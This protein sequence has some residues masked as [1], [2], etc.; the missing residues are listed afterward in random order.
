V[1]K[2]AIATMGFSFGG[3]S[4][5][6]AQVRNGIIQA[7]VS[8]DGSVRYQYPTLKKS[9][10][11]TIDK[12]NVPFI[13]MAQKIIP[14]QV[15]KED[16]IDP[17][18]NNDFFFYDELVESEAYSL[19]FNNLTHSYFSTL[20]VL[21]QPR[22]LRQDKSDNKILESYRWMSYYTLMFLNAYLKKDM[23]AKDF[24]NNDPAEQGVPQG[25]VS[26]RMKQAAKN[27]VE[28]EDFNDMAA[29][30]SYK[31]LQELYESIKKENPA[32]TLE[33]GK[34]NVLGLQLVLHPGKGDFGIEV[35]HLAVDLYP[36]SANLFD[37]L[38]ESY[39]FLGDEINAIKNFEKSLQL[40]PGN[41]NA[42]NRLAQL[43]RK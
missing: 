35:L 39:L 27:K 43:K 22:D 40:D 31:D 38:A 18:L 29:R 23:D 41:E 10:F 26:V 17:S 42:I 34:L 5:I 15:M 20:G 7:S 3:L 32:F 36:G 33:E 28:F 37:S 24:L 12:A 8:L 21:F 11:F 16:K 13:H 9:S 1:D 4:N 6:L 2:N 25:I 14:E 19:R 30:R